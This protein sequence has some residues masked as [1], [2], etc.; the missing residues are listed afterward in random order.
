MT[1]DPSLIEYWLPWQGQTIS[2]PW[3][4]VTGHPWWV[5]TEVKARKLPA[6]GWVMITAAAE[7][8]L[9]VPTGISDSAT[10]NPAGAAA[11]VDALAELGAVAGAAGVEELTGAAGLD[12]TAELGVPAELDT[13]AALGAPL[14]VAV[15]EGVE[16]ALLPLEQAAR[17]PAP[18]TPSPAR[19]ARRPATSAAIPLPARPGR[20]PTMF[21]LS[22]DQV[23]TVRGQPAS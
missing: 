20:L 8:Y 19:T 11:A 12:A 16:E 3:D 14:L 17:V 9:P 13:P 18:T 10:E 7:K 21:S 5:Q 23:T 2:A 4:W 6:V 22:G 1:T 15:A